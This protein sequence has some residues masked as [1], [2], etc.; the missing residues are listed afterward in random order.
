M[1]AHGVPNITESV[2]RLVVTE[3]EA[4]EEESEEEQ[5]AVVQ[6]EFC[7]SHVDLVKKPVD[8]EERSGQLPENKDAAIVVNKWSL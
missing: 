2:V 3:N 4:R 5:D 7:A 6:L 1:A 8:V